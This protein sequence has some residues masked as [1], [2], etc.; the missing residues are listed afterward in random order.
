MRDALPQARSCA[1]ESRTAVDRA[2]NGTAEQAMRLMILAMLLF[3]SMACDKTIREV[4]RGFPAARPQAELCM[5]P[6]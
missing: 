6:R 2:Q 1:G 5:L 4:R 3:I